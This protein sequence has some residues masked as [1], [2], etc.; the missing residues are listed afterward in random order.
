MVNKSDEMK[1][2]HKRMGHL[3]VKSMKKITADGLVR[4]IPEL[5]TSHKSTTQIN[6]TR[7]LELLHMDLM[8]PFQV[9]SL[10]GKN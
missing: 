10:S 4:G 9:E 8:G 3:N 6:T 5:K 1:L 7:P 2:W